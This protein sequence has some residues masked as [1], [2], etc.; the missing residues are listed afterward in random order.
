MR[1]N[2]AGWDMG[3]KGDNIGAGM[4]QVCAQQQVSGP[5]INGLLFDRDTNES[6][7]HAGTVFLSSVCVGVRLHPY[8]YFL[9]FRLARCEIGQDPKAAAQ[10]TG[11]ASNSLGVCQARWF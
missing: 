5:C 11:E 4:L 7:P 2:D 8:P 9:L 10:S 1:D 6:C 3:R